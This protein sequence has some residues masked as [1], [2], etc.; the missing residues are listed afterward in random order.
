MT[1][2]ERVLSAVEH[3]EPDGLPVGFKATDDVLEALKR[4]FEVADVPS[5]L[6]RLPVDTFGAFNNT[7]YG[8]YPKYVHGPP[9]V[10]YPGT[11][12]DGT[13][14]TIYGY[15]RR[16][17]PCKGG[18]N[19]EVVCWPLAHAETVSDLAGHPWPE[20]DWFVYDSIV[21]QC[22]AAG[23][24]A[25]IFNVGG[26]GHVANLIGYERVFADM[27]LNP[28]LLDAAL[29]RLAD[30][31]VEFSE[32]TF[33]AAKGRIDVAVIQDDFGSQ[34][35]P[36]MSLDMFRRFWKP[37]LA[38]F[39][40]VVRKYGV[41]AMMHSCGGVFSFIPDFLDMGVE[42]LD[43]VQTTAE[44]MKPKMLVRE[45]GDQLCFHGGVATQN[46][47]VHG[48]AGDIRRHVD[49]LVENLFDRGGFILAPTHYIQGDVPLENV[50]TVYEHVRRYRT[51]V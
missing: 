14:D 7:Y 46:L 12:P 40:A 26:L 17:V 30:F 32:R 51:G 6:D 24:R 8:I 5:L 27:H 19:D 48:S 37:H 15:K 43:P 42:I 2:R 22:A 13:W 35:G 49:N 1:P 20:A 16:W 21:D 23:P 29:T 9:K 3:R 10:L 39:F 45:F 4:H 34:R 18:F 50:L 36:L 31:Y 25:V 28:A 47:L 38:R 44:G 11:Y 33:R 41:K